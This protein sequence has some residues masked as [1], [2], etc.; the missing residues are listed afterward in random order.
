MQVGAANHIQAAASALE[1]RFQNEL[2][3]MQKLL[4]ADSPPSAAP[5]MPAPPA[6]Q[7][8][9]APPLPDLKQIPVSDQE[10]RQLTAAAQRYFHF[11]NLL[12]AQA[13]IMACARRGENVLA[14]LPTGGGK[15]L[16]YQLP[17]LM[18]G[19][20]TLVISPLIA[21]MKDQ[22]DSLPPQARRHALSLNSS[23]DGGQ[24]RRAVRMVANGRYRLVYAAPERLRQPPFLHALQHAGVSRLVVDEAHCISVWGHDFRPD[25]LYLSQARRALGAPP[26]LAVTATAP[27][28]VRRDIERRLL[29]ASDADQFRYVAADTYRANLHLS[30]YKVGNKKE[31]LSRVL[32]LCRESP[33]SGIVYA[34][35]RR[36][37]EQIAALLR[38]EGINAAHYHAGI[39]NR[40][41]VQDG[42]MNGRIRIIAATVAFGMGVDK[43]DIR[44]IIHYNLPRSVEA[45]YQEAGRAGRDGQPARCV[46][47]YSSSD[48]GTMTRHANESAIP[49]PYL[50]KLYAA[51]RQRLTGHGDRSAAQ[52]P[53]TGAIPPDDLVRDLCSDDT[54]VRVA[55]SILEQA[56]V[57]VR[58]SDAPRSVTLKW[59]NTQR[60][61]DDFAAFT[62]AARLRP[63]QVVDRAFMEIATAVGI[64]APQ[65][66]Q[67]LLQWQ[68][69]GC[70][71]YEANGRDWL[72][73]LPA[74][75]PADAATRIESLLSQYAAIQ[76]QRVSEIAAYANTRRCRHAFLANY[77]GGAPR[78]RCEA[79]DNCDA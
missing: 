47:I 58:H 71:T 49:L 22:I 65:L 6:P 12:P 75:P 9:T 7:K 64:P 27:A 34:R 1:Q 61:E 38:Q 5:S 26:V 15:S 4:A 33:G 73:A 56:G 28:P 14:I 10:R 52:E 60:A 39:P 42:F 55:L 77:L 53:L 21:L 54:T 43:P 36:S 35:S 79:C 3:E 25:Y 16:C 37:C 46:L 67:R 19:G 24:L 8:W 72:L 50:R 13:E 20:L 17:A 70:L 68:T 40:A 76:Q 30:V 62:A 31:K 57:L 59:R 48:K 41:A 11:P 51:I 69:A 78:Q 23:L 18:D 45:Y 63:E 44:F 2:R 29:D 74:S 66:E 32:A